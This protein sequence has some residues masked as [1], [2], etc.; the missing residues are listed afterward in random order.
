AA[1]QLD[2]KVTAAALGAGESANGVAQLLQQGPY[3]RFQLDVKRVAHQS[4]EQYASG[5]VAQVQVIQTLQV[6]QSQRSP[7]LSRERET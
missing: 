1:I 6:G 3:A 4:I 2:Q 7:Q 5:T